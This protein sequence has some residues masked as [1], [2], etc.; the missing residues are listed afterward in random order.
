MSSVIAPTDYVVKTRF[1]LDN[2]NFPGLNQLVTKVSSIDSMIRGLGAGLAAALG[3]AGI[4]SAIRSVV[5]LNKE[6]ENAELGIASLF[7]AM[8]G[9]SLADA[10]GAARVQV[11]GLREDAAMGAGEFDDY[12]RGFQMILGPA[13][14]AGGSVSQIRELNKLAIATAAAMNRPLWQA[15]QDVVQAM[16][17]GASSRTTPIIMQALGAN[18][19]SAETFNAAS[20]PE[21]LQ[22]LMSSFAL[23]SDAAAMM[24]KSWDARMA[25]FKDSVKD[26]ERQV[27]K[28][29]FDRW[30]EQLGRVNEWLKKNRDIMSDMA[31][32]I[33]QRLGTA[34]DRMSA[35][36]GG[37]AAGGAGLASAAVGGRV[38]VALGATPVGW[39]T[40]IGAAIFG[41]IGASITNA[42][43]R[44]PEL[45]A[46]LASHFGILFD[47][48]WRAVQGFARLMESPVW[49]DIGKFFGT[50]ADY[51]LKLGI[52]ILRMTSALL[53]QL[54]LAMK[55][56]DAAKNM[57][58]AQVAGDTVG[59]GIW[60]G[61]LRDYNRAGEILMTERMSKILD[62]NGVKMPSSK[63][64]DAAGETNTPPVFNFGPGS[65]TIKIE[66]ER[67][68]DPNVVAMTFDAVMKR[69]AAYPR[70]SNR[71]L[72]VP[73]ER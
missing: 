39:I 63:D 25:T 44:F 4:A 12:L 51:G 24:A 23:F 71:G 69:L 38:A 54:D 43:R 17:S 36:G 72:F 10:M 5:S 49:S 30:S 66:T 70:S 31:D 33:G 64:K 28:P 11:R 7:S 21:R 45:G 67:L 32:R 22:M 2:N 20:G 46:R 14:S 29:L 59:A 65:V 42:I 35:N 41:M 26:V 56:A 57:V 19:I 52:V 34:Y 18:K 61:R 1:D 68:D 50:I 15:P 48:F 6:V 40:A 27:S 8:S 3:G 58:L 62:F 73:K 13:G 37:L 55:M 9:M 53:E 16:T 60:G 47:E